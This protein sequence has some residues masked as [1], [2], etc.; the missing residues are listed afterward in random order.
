VATYFSRRLEA[1]VSQ[2]RK[3]MAEDEIKHLKQELMVR[4]ALLSSQCARPQ[5]ELA[6]HYWPLPRLPN[7]GC[8]S[9]EVHGHGLLPVM[10]RHPGAR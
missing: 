7:R 4:N 5:T 9:E 3:T 8:D 1:S 6:A 10:A 2:E